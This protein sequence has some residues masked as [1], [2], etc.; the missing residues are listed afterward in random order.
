[1]LALGLLLGCGSDDGSEGERLPSLGGQTGEENGGCQPVER[2]Q[3]AWSE[4]STLGF[5]ADELLTALGGEEAARLAWSGGGG[6]A[7]ALRIERDTSSNVE[8]QTRDVVSNGSGAE[9]A[10]EL[11]ITCNDVVAIP[12]TLSFATADGAFAERWPVTLLAESRDRV[13]AA[14][15]V[16]VAD[17]EGTFTVTEVDPSHFDRVHVIAELTYAD[18]E[19]TGTLAGRGVSAT[20]SDPDGA[21]SAD[22]FA[23]AT[24]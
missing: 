24:F 7:L 9:P 6:T 17:L 8:L 13:T 12:V 1:M 10:I 3:L 20:S 15:E 2:E 19:W 23:I 21:T 22:V 14:V 11:A 5:S 18:A 4:R 16:D